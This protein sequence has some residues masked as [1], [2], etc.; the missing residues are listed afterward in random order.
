MSP[1]HGD[2]WLNKMELGG[3]RPS[4]DSPVLPVDP[5]SDPT[6]YRLCQ[7]PTGAEGGAPFG[8]AVGPRAGRNAERAR[9]TR[10]IR[11]R[12]DQKRSRADYSQSTWRPF[13]KFEP[14]PQGEVI[15]S[16]YQNW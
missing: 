10:V 5:A 4:Y 16:R 9:I 6:A 3:E 2:S 11:A 8:R 15:G 7:C 14:V 1:H 13:E 12:G